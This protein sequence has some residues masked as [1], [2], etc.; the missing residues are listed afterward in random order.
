MLRRTAL[1]AVV[2]A[3]VLGSAETASANTSYRFLHFNVCGS[4]SKDQN[5]QCNGGAVDGIALHVRAAIQDYKPYMV[6][7]NEICRSQFNKML[8]DLNS[9]GIWSMHAHF[10]TTDTTT[11]NCEGGGGDFGNAILVREPIFGTPVTTNLPHVES[12]EQRKV[13]CLVTALARGTVVCNTH[14]GTTEGYQE[15]QIIAVRNAVEPF[16]TDGTPTVLMGDFNVEP[17]ERRT[18][19]E[20]DHRLLDRIYDI[21][22]PD[23]Y[24]FGLFRELDDTHTSTTACRCGQATTDSN[25]RKIDYIF[26]SRY[27]WT[28][29]TAYVNSSLYSDH[30]QIRGT[31]TLIH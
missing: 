31:A 3:L 23:P 22:Y 13:T 15:D 11:T 17:N 6:S 9:A 5:S 26:V 10:T 21:N 4:V 19:P 27:D 16:V 18:A 12:N 25:T 28:G 14:I 2:L 8:W 24:G 7:L 1:V 30:H 20:P 29:L